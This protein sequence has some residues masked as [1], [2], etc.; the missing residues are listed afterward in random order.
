[1]TTPTA[2]TKKRYE[3]L[4][5]RVG[6]VERWVPQAR[7]RIDL[8]GIF[9]LLAISESETIGIQATTTTNL[10]ARVR[11]LREA[12]IL[13]LWLAAPGRRAIVIG[14]SRRGPWGA[15]KRWQPR[16]LELSL[17]EGGVVEQTQAG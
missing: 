14:W 13:P 6:T 1:M 10:S 12:E 5:Y 16:E 11:K 7:R 2:R 8:Y 17:G 15:V 4:G 9:D 3:R